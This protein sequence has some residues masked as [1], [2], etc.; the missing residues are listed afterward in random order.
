MFEKVSTTFEIRAYGDQRAKIIHLPFPIIE[1]MDVKVTF[2]FERIF[3]IIDIIFT[4][5][6]FF[7][8]TSGRMF[9]DG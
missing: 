7:K 3:Q 2:V 8:L 4:I 9:Y 1:L 5:M 6:D